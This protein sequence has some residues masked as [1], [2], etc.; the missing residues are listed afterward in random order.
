V[1][2]V[3]DDDDRAEE[4][5]AALADEKLPEPKAPTATPAR[6]EDE[7]RPSSGATAATAARP[8]AEAPPDARP[9]RLT[10]RVVAFLVALIV[11]VAAAVAAVGW[12]ARHTYYVGLDRNQVAIFKGRPGG[13]LWFN[14]TLERRTTLA[15]QD[16]LPSRLSDLRSGRSEASLADAQRYVN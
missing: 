6:D 10:W 5:S 15:Q 14:P 1:I 7:E 12:Y 2:D 4:A 13:L 8:R 16:V 11:V 3:V 9:R